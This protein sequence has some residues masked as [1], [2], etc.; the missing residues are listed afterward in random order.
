MVAG[1]MVLFLLGFGILLTTVFVRTSTLTRRQAVQQGTAQAKADSDGVRTL[2]TAALATG[3]SVARSM[4]QLKAAGVTDRAVYDRLLRSTLA[5]NPQYIALSSAWLPNALDG[6][7][8]NYRNTPG[9]DATGRYLSYWNRGSGSIALESLV[10]YDT[11]GAGDYFLV[12]MRTGKE[13]VMDPYS[14]SV[15]GKSVLMTSVMLPITVDHRRV[16]VVGIDIP[17]AN[18]QTQI[19]QIKPYRTGYAAL[20]TSAAIAVANPNT[21]LAGK[22]L[23]DTTAA[24]A[25]VRAANSNR[26][27]VLTGRDPA[28]GRDAIRVLVPV[29]V[30]P[31]ANWVFSISMPADAVLAEQRSL[32]WTTIVLATVLVA[33][34]FLGALLLARSLARPLLNLAR[35]MTELADTGDLSHRV[36]DTRSDEIGALGTSFNRFTAAMAAVVR[37]VQ[38]GIDGLGRANAEIGAISQRMVTTSARADS[39]V[40]SL[41]SSASLVTGNAQTVAASVEEMSASIQEISAGSGDAARVADEAVQQAEDA[42]T[43]VSRLDSSGEEIGRV[44]QLIT[45]IAGQTNL[46]ALNATIEAAR[47]GEAGKGFAVV[48]NEVKELARQTAQATEDITAKVASI[49][50]DTAGMVT[51]IRH[52]GEIITQIDD[53]QTSIAS[54]VEE[55][56]A[57][58]QEI[59][60]GATEAAT[61]AG[62]ISGSVASVAEATDTTRADADAV[63]QAATVLAGVTDTL[64]QAVSQLRV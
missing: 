3:S 21:A 52:I 35:R 42:A 55:Q 11:P 29:E 44:V 22:K 32:R 58:T 36:D 1:T 7:D 37:A 24:A 15:A 25:T 8:R 43:T 48:A 33:V 49:R 19:G 20:S 30:T 63:E 31:G 28:L 13:W 40:Q 57:T 50:S 4:G 41:A 39:E 45:Q 16:G 38:E 47:A 5:D 26:P 62:A 56:T 51:V 60:R 2:L 10:D 59:G 6:R 9:S 46:L 54:A 61:A 18:L 27:V 64:R 12:P 53:T 14:Y 34:A 23:T 17:L